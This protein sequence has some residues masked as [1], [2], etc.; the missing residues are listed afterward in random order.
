MVAGNIQVNPKLLEAGGYNKLG[1]VTETTPDNVGDNSKV[2]E[3]L[4]EWGKN[5]DWFSTTTDP[6]APVSKNLTLTAFYNSV[7]TDI[8]TQTSN[9]S[10]SAEQRATS[11]TNIENERQAMSGVSQDEEFTNMIKYQYAYNASARMVT[12]LDSM[13][14]TIINGL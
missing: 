1:T 7:V 11:V 5:R 4:N 3:F 10:N 8:G 14:D 2:T 13:L 6:A 12:M 9:Y